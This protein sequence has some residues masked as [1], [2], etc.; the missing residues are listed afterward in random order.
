MLWN[1]FGIKIDKKKAIQYFEAAAEKG[2]EMSMLKCANLYTTGIEV[3]RDL[4]K[5][6]K[7]LK[8]AANKLT[9]NDKSLLSNVSELEESF[10]YVLAEHND[11]NKT[12]IALACLFIA[13]QENK[14]TEKFQYHS[15]IASLYSKVLSAYCYSNMLYFGTGTPVNKKESIKYLTLAINFGHPQSMLQ[16]G[17]ML[18]SGDEIEGNILEGLKYLKKAADKECLD[19]MYRYGTLLYEGKICPQNKEEGEKYIIKAKEENQFKSLLYYYETVKNDQK[20]KIE[21]IKKGM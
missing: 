9:I 14:N 4:T 6:L 3:E 15:E 10:Y 18:I 8:K 16:Y 12:A 7:Y 11:L 5:A 20:G 17:N 1:G 13:E 21:I 19:A 2:N